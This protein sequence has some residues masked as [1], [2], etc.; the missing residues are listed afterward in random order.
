MCSSDLP[1][2]L[3][4][5]SS[6]NVSQ[7][8]MSGSSI[9]SVSRS[10]FNLTWSGSGGDFMLAY[11]AKRPSD[12]STNWEEVVT[13]AMTDDGSFTVPSSAFSSWTSSRYVD[14]VIGRVT[15]PGGIVPYNDA[16]V[17]FAGTYWVW[18][19]SRMQ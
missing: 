7:P 13:C 3:D 8:N 5:P 18:G 14:V 9:P 15:M 11:L 17:G 1:D 12:A 19:L 16:N 10:A 6:F 4:L 2:V